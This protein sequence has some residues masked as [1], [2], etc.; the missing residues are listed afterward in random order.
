MPNFHASQVSSLALAV[1]L[2]L[3]SAPAA[4]AAPLDPTRPAPVDAPKAEPDKKPEP[5][6]PAPK[7]GD[8]PDDYGPPLV[9]PPGGLAPKKPAEPIDP[10]EAK[11]LIKAV[12]VHGNQRIGDDR[13]LLSI[14]ITPGDKVGRSDVMDAIQRIYGMGYFQDVKAGSEPVAGGER[15]V[16]TVVENPVMG[17]V[18]FEG[19]TKVDPK[20]LETLFQPMKGDTINY[21]TIKEAVDKLQKTYADAGFPLARVADMSVAP[22]GILV[23]RIAEGKVH[24]VKVAGN[25]ETK[26]YVVLRE[27][28]TKPGE[29]FSSEKIKAD[30]RRIY[31]LNYF[32]EINLKFEPAPLP[33]EVVVVIEVK[34][35]QTGS[36]N[37]GAGYST[38]DGIL[39]MFSV[40]KDNLFG[41]GQQVGVDLSISQQFRV[42]GELTYFNPWFDD[43]RTGLG[44]SVYLRRFNN[45]LANFREDRVGISANASRPL[46]GDSLGSPWRGT[47]GIRAES[48]TTYDNVFV[49]GNVKPRFAAN[50]GL[51]NKP[52]T[53][54]PSGTDAIVAGS[55]GITF[56]TR[57]VIMNP[58]EGWFNQV[59]LEPGVVNPGQLGTGASPLIRTSG[60]AT[61]FVPLPALPWSKDRSTLAIGGRLGLIY[62]PQVPA[63]ERFYSTGPYLV[64]GWP[65][66][67]TPDSDPWRKYP[68]NFFQGSNTVIGSLEYRFPIFNIVSGVVF[69]DSGMFWDDCFNTS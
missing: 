51:P 65:E 36:I 37:L 66:F 27:V 13:I 4:T 53:L 34:E 35:K 63:Y 21:N 52:I 50:D 29:I 9:A 54:D 5:A 42:A 24:H 69:A 58:T 40:K 47:A 43:N 8:V 68:L 56:D 64:R 31:N 26:E 59:T 3:A 17:D 38:R 28:S 62:G 67:A 33:E 14:P 11:T 1:A 16:F 55:L 48:V 44:G 60:A 57:D 39:G 30:L 19:V 61:Y 25:E 22:G 18:T 41:T 15:L 49:G 2:T 7:P 46:F 23:L 45:F 20:K 10:N 12:T 32:E 6:K